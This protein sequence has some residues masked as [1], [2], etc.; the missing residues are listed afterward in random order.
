[1]TRSRYTLAMLLLGMLALPVANAH[2]QAQQKNVAMMSVSSID[3]LLGNINYLTEAAG[4][5]EFGQML[6]MMSAGY[7]EGIDRA[8]PVGIIL[9]TDGQQEFLPLGFVPVK[10][11]SK[12]LSSMEESVGRP[13]DLGNGIKE[14]PNFPPIFMKE[15]NGWAFIG[16]TVESMANLPKDPVA[17][18]GQLPKDYDVAIRG[19]VQNVPK[20]YIDMAV[21]ALQDGVRQ[22]I[23]NMPEDDQKGQK[24]LIESQMKQMETFI[25]E[26]DQITIGWKTEPAEKRTFLDMTFT[27]VPGGAL[28]KQM[29]A[30]ANAKSDFT[31]FMLPGAAMTMNMS[32]EIP[33][34]Q[35]QTSVD[36][37]EG[38]KETIMR[39]IDKDENLEDDAEMAAA[40][41]DMVGAAM[42]ILSE[43]MKTGKIDGGASV[44]L[45]PGDITVLAGFH[46]ADGDEI[47][48]V[49]KKAADAAKSE[50][51]FP[52]INFNADRSNGVEFHTMTVPVPED[53]EA[54]SILGNTLTMA[55]GTSKDSA[56]IGLGQN[57]VAQLKTI[58]AQQPKQKSAPPFQMTF[59][60]TPI[61][62]FVSGIED[63]PLVGS[64]LEGLQESANKDHVKLHGL[65]VKNGF[66]YRIEMEEGVLRAIGEAV[67][68]SSAGGF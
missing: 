64:V 17:E 53:E 57:C 65:P 8:N 31:G 3:S 19:I 40:A 41:K 11:L 66:T 18:L 21:S 62:E 25:K 43:T 44:M 27:A 32:S 45:K 55:I 26:S 56:Y 67:Q 13:K 38:L 54:R 5:G 37:I 16:Q 59:A 34:E 46:V 4:A 68:M 12:V 23:E 10:D 33:E 63:N 22:G 1:M 42:D 30:M 51:E 49:L 50:P 48:K 39:E 28:A 52:G 6:G 47:V 14:I 7:L 29:N 15:Q 36:M 61:M 60:L 9:T 35:I 2:A 20:Q 24:A 58:I